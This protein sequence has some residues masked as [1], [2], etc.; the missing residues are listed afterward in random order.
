MGVMY[1][2]IAM[3]GKS[4]SLEISPAIMK[5]R[6]GIGGRCVSSMLCL[7]CLTDGNMA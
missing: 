3:V 7:D 2:G 6:R 1:E 4:I 5:G